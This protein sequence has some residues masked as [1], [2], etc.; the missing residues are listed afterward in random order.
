MFA[1]GGGGAGGGGNGGAEG[2]GISHEEDEEL[3]A[4]TLAR[5]ITGPSGESS[6]VLRLPEEE[7]SSRPRSDQSQSVFRILI[8][9]EFTLGSFSGSG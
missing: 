1:G 2:T 5:A 4:G 9:R 7:G 8:R 6:L 3:P